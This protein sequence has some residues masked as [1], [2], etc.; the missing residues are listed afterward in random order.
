MLIEEK[1]I[2][3]DSDKETLNTMC[4]FVGREIRRRRKERRLSRPDLC[5]RMPSD[6]KPRTIRRH[7]SGH[8][9]WWVTRLVE[10]SAALTISPAKVLDQ[11][12][13]PAKPVL[14][15]LLT[16]LH[17]TVE[18]EGSSVDGLFTPHRRRRD[19]SWLVK[20]DQVMLNKT[21]NKAAGAEL[22]KIRRHR[23][24][25]QAELASKLPVANCTRTVAGVERGDRNLTVPRLIEFCCVLRWPPGDILEQTLMAMKVASMS[26]S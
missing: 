2:V 1:S 20:V 10:M 16:S 25:T 18:S 9:R 26:S 8:S 6:I 21:L 24:L 22:A 23:K 15:P 17:G 4:K 7:E 11:A 19:T 13:D 5:E 12:M 14:L 3:S